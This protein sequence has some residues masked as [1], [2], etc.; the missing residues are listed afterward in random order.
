[1]AN[2][3]YTRSQSLIN[4]AIADADDVESKFARVESGFDLVE[5]DIDRVLAD[6]MNL[7]AKADKV[8][9]AVAGNFAAL[10][11]TGNLQDSGV[12]SDDLSDTA[13]LSGEETFT[14][15]KIFR[16]TSETV[17][18]LVGDQIDPANGSIQ[19]K[20]L[21]SNTVLSSGLTAGQSVTLQIQSQGFSVTWPTMRWVGG[22]PPDFGASSTGEHVMVLWHDGIHLNGSYIGL[23]S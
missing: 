12:S 15:H 10:D 1:M 16:E 11:A 22:A 17:Y 21:S 6:E 13:H 5:R 3:Y 9:G 4:G 2:R 18:T 23:L 14:G 19:K 20:V 8:P 7:S